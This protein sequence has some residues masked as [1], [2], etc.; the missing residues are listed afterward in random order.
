MRSGRSVLVAAFG[1]ALAVALPVAFAG[2]S[3]DPGVSAT[4]IV[5]GGTSP[6]TGPAASY[7]SVARGAKAYFEFV[8]A[9]GGVSKR[10]IDYRIV[11]DAYNPAQ[12][13]QAVR[14]LVEQD[15]VF[16]V[17]NTLGTEANL[18]IRD[19]LNQIKVPQLFVASG[20][21][22]WGRD[23]AKYPWTIGFQPSYA[24][25][26]LV[27]GQYIARAKKKAKVAVL[28]QNDDYGKDLLSSLKLGLGRSGSK[29]VAAEPY[30]VTSPDVGSQVAKLKASGAN[31]LCI[32]ATPTFAIQAYVFANRLGWKPLVVNNAVSG[33]S[34][35]MVLASE[36]GK[37]K[38]VEG[39][40]TTTVLKDPTDPRWKSDAGMKQYRAL[41]ARYAKGAQPR[42][43]L[44]RVRHG[45]RLRDG[46]AVQ[47]ARGESH[48]G[49]PD[50][51][52][53]LDLRREEPVPPSGRV[54]EDGQGRRLPDPA[55]PA[56][57]AGRRAASCRSAAS[58]RRSGTSLS[59]WRP[60]RSTAASSIRRGGLAGSSSTDRR[61]DRRLRSGRSRRASG[62][63]K[64]SDDRGGEAAHDLLPRA[65][66][67]GQTPHR[68]APRAV[69]HAD[70]EP[71]AD[72]GDARR[73]AVRRQEGE[74]LREPG[75]R[76]GLRPRAALEAVVLARP[77]LD[78]VVG[79]LLASE[80]LATFDGDERV[81]EAAREGDAQ[82]LAQA[83]GDHAQV[84]SI[85][86][87]GEHRLREPTLL[88]AEVAI[89][90]AAS[91]I[92]TSVGTD[93]E[94]EEPDSRMT[95]CLAR[96]ERAPVP[97]REGEMVERRGGSKRL[98]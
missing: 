26:G 34:N 27:Y 76:R 79:R 46:G 55:G 44:P 47:A 95:N 90:G 14:R 94:P 38:L 24:A 4:T 7:A 25:E 92:Q 67:D 88:H 97:A 45:G 87:H 29:V 60:S 6:L 33:T 17:F 43:R 58:G 31:V 50:E 91:R 18:A 78:D 70:E 84:A 48:P 74:R 10:K 3:A 19:Y 54:R 71:V 8:N 59:R 9:G 81:S 53:A 12:T 80:A 82:R 86:P 61:C 40:I 2:S 41:L 15:R 96:R 77:G 13:V 23:A 73:R 85:T 57:S 32:F 83:P 65:T 62:R 37:N 11:D 89:L 16:A 64:P 98:A 36:G 30:Q 35:I 1:A 68:R 51:G 72:R 39:T 21:T 56:G 49:G 63:M 28:F 22:T 20:A 42:R 66:R 52:G 69:E 75:A 93:G 5:I